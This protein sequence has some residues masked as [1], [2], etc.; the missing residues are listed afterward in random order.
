[1]PN[2]N[3]ELSYFRNQINQILESEHTKSLRDMN[4]K[5]YLAKI[6]AKDE[7]GLQLISACCSEAKVKQ[8][9]IKYLKEIVWHG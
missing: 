8:S 5:K 9:E 4:E 2:T 3:T 7:Q 1:M 6:I